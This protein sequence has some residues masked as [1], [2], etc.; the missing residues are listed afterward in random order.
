MKNGLILDANDVKKILASY[1][2]VSENEII[3]SQYS[4]T[5][6]GVTEEDFRDAAER[7]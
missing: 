1:F 5:I 7:K 2:N 3:K 4:Y 6:M